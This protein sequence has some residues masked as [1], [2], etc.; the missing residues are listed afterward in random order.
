[1][2]IYNGN[3]RKQITKGN[4]KNNNNNDHNNDNK[5]ER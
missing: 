4:D 3:G 2:I 1:M 5:K